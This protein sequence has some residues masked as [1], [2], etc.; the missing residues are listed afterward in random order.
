MTVS[1]ILL[2]PGTECF[3]H[4]L[5]FTVLRISVKKGTQS[6]EVSNFGKYTDTFCMSI[7]VL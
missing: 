2:H 6:Y 1:K 3:C 4:Y 7:Y 5:H